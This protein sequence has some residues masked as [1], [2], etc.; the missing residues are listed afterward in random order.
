MGPIPIHNGPSKWDLML[1]MFDPWPNNGGRRV[2][3]FQ[4]EDGDEMEVVINTIKRNHSL[5]YVLAGW[6][7]D[8]LV[9]NLVDKYVVGTYNIQHRKGELFVHPTEHGL[10][11]I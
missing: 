4:S 2:L 8:S 1:A 9:V 5:E 11:K 10:P 7:K 3:T 6:V